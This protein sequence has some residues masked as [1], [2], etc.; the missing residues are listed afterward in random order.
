MGRPYQ[1]L[2][3]H[4]DA[5]LMKSFIL[6]LQFLTTIRLS[7]DLPFIEGD[8]S[9]SLRWFPLIGFLIGLLQ[10]S[11]AGMFFAVR[12]P[13]ELNALILVMAGLLITGGLHLDGVA[14]SLDGFGA[15]RDRESILRI[16]KDTRLGVFGTAGIVLVLLAKI[17]AFKYVIFSNALYAIW[18]APILSRT[19]LVVACVLLPYAREDGTGKAFASGSKLLHLLPAIVVCVVLVCLISGVRGLWIAGIASGIGLV[20]VFY[21]YR[22]ISGFT[23]D[24]LGL[25]NELVEISALFSAAALL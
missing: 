6:A 1:P 25:L 13:A 3:S 8:F 11:L 10:W 22:K 24:T 7:K 23:G 20:F 14:D 17:F 5:K 4:K 15:G 2:V 18:F 12:M 9:A 21:C 19:M 16:M